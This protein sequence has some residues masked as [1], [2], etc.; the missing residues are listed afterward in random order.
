[1]QSQTVKTYVSAI[2][3]VLIDD[4]YTWDN[5]KILLTSLTRGCRIINDRVRTRL[6][7]Q[8]NLLELILF[9]VQRIFTDSSQYYLEI[10]YKALFALGYYGLF[11]VGELTLSPHVIKASNVHVA[12]NQDKILIVLY[13]SKTHGKEKLRQKSQNHFK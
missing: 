3:R 1:M 8:C 13:T 12:T 9:E 10:L 7:I 4:G 2:K 5:T 6:P 11:R